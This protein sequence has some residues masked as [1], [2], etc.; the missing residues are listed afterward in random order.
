[1]LSRSNDTHGRLIAHCREESLSYDGFQGGSQQPFQLL[2]IQ[3]EDLRRVDI[4]W[5]KQLYVVLVL[6]YSVLKIKAK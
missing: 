4:T 2:W 1:M 5:I 3:T 6:Y